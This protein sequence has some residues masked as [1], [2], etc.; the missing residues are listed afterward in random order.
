MTTQLRELLILLDG[1][2]EALQE[3][4]FHWWQADT[5]WPA[6]VNRWITQSGA[7]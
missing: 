7:A 5:V 2:D 1:L 3:M 4:R 6:A